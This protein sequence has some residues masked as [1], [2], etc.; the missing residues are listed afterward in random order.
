[1]N[2]P[3]PEELITTATLVREIKGH[4]FE[5]ILTFTIYGELL[6]VE[7]DFLALPIEAQRL[8]YGKEVESVVDSVRLEMALFKYCIPLVAL[9][10]L[11]GEDWSIIKEK[12]EALVQSKGRETASNRYIYINDY[13]VKDAYL[14]RD[15][16]PKHQH[17][18]CLGKV[19]DTKGYAR[20]SAIDNL[21]R[22][23]HSLGEEVLKLLF[24]QLTKE[25]EINAY[26]GWLKNYNSEENYKLLSE[27][28][29]DEK[30][31]TYL[32]SGIIEGLSTYE[33][34]NLHELLW[35]YQKDRTIR[36]GKTLE[37][38]LKGISK[39]ESPKSKQLL[40]EHLFSRHYDVSVFAC[41]ELIEKW[42][43]KIG[44]CKLL[45]PVFEERASFD[46]MVTVLRHYE[47]IDNSKLSP[48][49]TELLD[50]FEWSCN[51]FAE[52]GL[53]HRISNLIYKRVDESE[54]SRILNYL[55][56]EKP[57]YRIGGLELLR[58]TAKIEHAKLITKILDDKEDKVVRKALNVLGNYTDKF[59]MPFLV[60]KLL[61][62]IQNN[63]AEKINILAFL[64][65]ALEKAPLKEAIDPL[66]SILENS[67]EVNEKV[68]AMRGLKNYRE[69][70]VKKV[71][72]KLSESS[73]KKLS[74]AALSCL[75]KGNRS[76]FQ[77]FT[78]NGNDIEDLI[79]ERQ[80]QE[81]E[82]QGRVITPFQRWTNKW[83]VK[84]K[85]KWA[86]WKG[87]M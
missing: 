23:P 72:M 63:H 13:W 67:K 47:R 75:V 9:G 74:A 8:M 48:T 28:L 1:M 55:K 76:L 29:K 79:I 11:K 66:L 53:F 24:P 38:L 3:I 19:L 58:R 18:P 41:D 33:Y 44:V 17:L 43:G 68:Y 40:E 20:G 69:G 5:F 70:R 80:F 71:L 21:S 61:T 30:T 37:F 15:T 25:R 77:I 14:L 46:R 78:K 27:K 31:S 52:T 50:L 54:E 34:P 16:S 83:Y 85:W 60:K 73:D 22:Y 86:R 10:Q 51:N 7:N 57:L 87:E 82:K 2:N 39:F 81:L 32:H 49:V 62:L 84:L 26:Y 4:P 45:R 35:N 42:L 36:N 59:K 12:I 65:Y 6:S 56:E 64:Q